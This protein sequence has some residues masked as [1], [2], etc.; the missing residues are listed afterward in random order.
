MNKHETFDEWLERFFEYTHE[1]YESDLLLINNFE[2]KRINKP[3]LDFL[4]WK[5]SQYEPKLI[6]NSIKIVNK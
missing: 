2:K 3:L 6:N 4:K 1:D 5:T